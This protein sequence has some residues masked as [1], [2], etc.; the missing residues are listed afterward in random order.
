MARWEQ[1]EVWLSVNDKWEMAAAFTELDLATAM[2]KN[3]SGNMRLIHAIY[4]GDRC[5]HKDVLVDL[6]AT[7][8][9]A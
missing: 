7:R 5:V 9:T 6:G 8:R 3:Y 2:S 1:Y 4:E